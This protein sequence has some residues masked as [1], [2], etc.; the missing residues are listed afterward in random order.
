MMKTL[1]SLVSLSKRSVL[2]RQGL[3]RCSRAIRKTPLLPDFH[4]RQQQHL[5]RCFVHMTQV[6]ANNSSPFDSSTTKDNASSSKPVTTR[7]RRKFIPPKAAV[8]LS[9]KAR[10]FFKLLLEKPPRPD[11]VG[12]YYWGC[13]IL[14]NSLR[15]LMMESLTLSYLLFL[16]CRC[17]LPTKFTLV[18]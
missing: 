14:C 17:L 15:N 4:H 5:V 10:K 1:A 18:L 16:L 9:D 13:A 11:V 7:E 8:K 6:V 12:A 3:P 2:R